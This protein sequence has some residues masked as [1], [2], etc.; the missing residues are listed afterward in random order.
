MNIRLEIKGV[1]KMETVQPIRDKQKIQEVKD[2]L[3]VKNYRDYILF[4]MGIN[5]GLRISDLL[6]LKVIDVKDKT[7]IVIR[8]DKT[9]KEKRFPLSSGIKEY[10][11]PYIKGMDDNEYLFQSRQ[12]DNKPLDRSQAYRIINEACRKAGIKDQIGTHTLR[13]TFGYHHYQKN[14]DVAILQDIFNH[15]APSV[16][17]RYIGINDDLKDNS[18]K[19][20]CL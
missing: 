10:I 20:F 18:L 17:L 2:I 4:C 12:G 6:K 7:H 5:V 15:S 13:K 16:T 19:D 11:E 3:K 8:E 1:L 9:N 14:K